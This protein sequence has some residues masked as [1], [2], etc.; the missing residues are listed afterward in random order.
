MHLSSH[1]LL[2]F[3]FLYFFVHI[4]SNIVLYHVYCVEIAIE[5]GNIN[6]G[7]CNLYM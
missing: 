3:A 1:W 4:L 5:W 7:Q 6:F 2:G